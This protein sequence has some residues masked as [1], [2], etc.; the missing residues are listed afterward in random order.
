[1]KHA[2]LT[3]ALLLLAPALRAQG[4][5]SGAAQRK[6]LTLDDIYD[7]EKKVDFIGSSSADFTWVGDTHY[8]WSRT[9]PKKKTTT[10]LKVQALSGTAQAFFD[11]ARMEQ[12]LTKLGGIAPKDAHAAAHQASYSMNEDAT[13]VLVTLD[14]DLYHFDIA[15]YR[16]QRLTQAAGVEEETSFSPDGKRAAFVRGGNLFVVD[17]ATRQERGLTQDGSTDV[18]NGKL[19]WI[20]QEEIFGR[21]NFRGYWWSPDSSRIAFLRLDEQDVPR[22]TLVDDIP[23]RPEVETTPYPKAGDRNPKVKLGIVSVTSG[24]TRW[25]GLEGSE[26]LLVVDVSWTPGGRHVVYQVQDREQTWLDLCLAEAETGRARRV[27]REVTDTWVE[28]HGSPHWL[29][30]GSFLWTSERSGFA[31]LYHY[32]SDGTLVRQLTQGSWEVSKLHGVDESAGWVY[33]AATERSSLT[34]DAYRARTDGTGLARLTEPAGTHTAQFNKSLTLFIDRWSD[35]ATPAQARLHRADGGD[36]RVIDPN[37]VP[38]LGEYR[39]SKPEFHQ[40]K[41]RDG[42]SMEAMILKPPGFDPT[43]R[44]PVYQ[45]TYAGPHAPQVRNAWGGTPFM[46]YQLLAQ[47]GIVVF[48]CDNRTASGKGAAST[49]P[50]YKRLGVTEMADIEDGAAWLK[51]QSWV[52]ASRIGIG[53]WSYGGFMVSY[54]LT[55]SR[56]FAMG[57]AGGPVTDWRDYDSIYTERYMRTPRNNP[58]GYRDTAPRFAAKDLHGKLLLIHGALDDNVHPQ[59]TL[60]FAH[61]LQ[62]AGKPFRMML[63][64]KS[65]HAVTDP[66]LVKHLRMTMLEFIEETLLGDAERS[67]TDHGEH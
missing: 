21:G 62:K 58:E 24:E 7:P 29:G 64:P 59:N 11:A 33:F 53:G 43:R 36:V 10:I 18:L 25:I 44:Y 60:Q 1:M 67:H 48:L 56:A 14:D 32:R 2:T 39:L 17:L 5:P 50:S 52:D 46:F 61:E 47:R 34:Q 12:A 35:T 13:A 65:R 3:L 66:A 31:H 57:I 20:Y 40:I 28:P 26:E 37:L 8:L 54:A 23:Y 15:S 4:A 49:W 19:D 30:D 9:D 38:A 51:D 45:H 41:T 6:T 42:F 55:H 22:Y 16:A 27:L 63:Y